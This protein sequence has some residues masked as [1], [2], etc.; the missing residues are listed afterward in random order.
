MSRSATG[1]STCKHAGSLG[2][3]LASLAAKQV[4]TVSL[5]SSLMG[6]KRPKH[7][8]LSS[9]VHCVDSSAETLGLCLISE[10][11]AT[12]LSLFFRK[13]SP[14]QPQ[15]ASR[16]RIRSPVALRSAARCLASLLHF[17]RENTLKLIWLASA[18]R[19]DQTTKRS[20]RAARTLKQNGWTRDNE[21]SITKRTAAAA[22]GRS[23]PPRVGGGGC[24]LVDTN[25]GVYGVLVH[26]G[27]CHHFYTTHTHS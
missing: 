6:A 12:F 5:L 17:C 25:P 20:S 23:C 13:E 16:S 10:R 19:N 9:R 26:L 1:V 14:A 27:S 2:T 4:R 24:P 15:A 3:S 22:S 11:T 7:Q 8:R 18:A 21:G